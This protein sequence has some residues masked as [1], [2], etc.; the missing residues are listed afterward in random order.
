MSTFLWTGGVR[1]RILNQ[2]GG[3]KGKQSIEQMQR[4]FFRKRQ[5]DE[6]IEHTEVT[7]QDALFEKLEFTAQ[8][9]LPSNLLLNKPHVMREMREPNLAGK[10]AAQTSFSRISSEAQ[11]NWPLGE[12]IINDETIEQAEVTVQ[13]ALFEKL[14]FTA[15]KKLSSNL[16]LNKSQ[17]V[18]T[19]EPNLAG[20]LA[21]QTCE[22][23]R[24]LP[25]GKPIIAQTAVWKRDE[26]SQLKSQGF[27]KMTSDK[28]SNGSAQ[29]T[30]IEPPN[31]P[32]VFI[33]LPKPPVS[34]TSQSHIPHGD[35]RKSMKL[36]AASSSHI[37][38]DVSKILHTIIE[39]SSSDKKRNFCDSSIQTECFSQPELPR[40]QLHNPTQSFELNLPT[41][42]SG[43]PP[44]GQYL[45]SQFFIPFCES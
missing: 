7:V 14:E 5:N 6:A 34:M 23:Q 9:K 42:F 37:S 2:A 25:L 1:K 19:R 18:I 11:R 22:A 4:D 35:E 24:N 45:F 30:T 39:D 13:D 29:L 16:M 32:K 38:E 20:K 28:K 10:A 15:N 31:F 40:L 12:P 36:L 44:R 17:Q 8:K 21:A 26:P 43:L 3:V 27:Y 41:N 33:S